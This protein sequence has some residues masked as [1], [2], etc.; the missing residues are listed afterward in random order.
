M[1]HR[2]RTLLHEMH[3]WIAAFSGLMLCT[4]AIAQPDPSLW[5]GEEE[6]ADESDATA[7]DADIHVTEYLTVDLNVQDTDLATVLQAL[8]MQSHKNIVTT[9]NVS[10]SISA[11][12][13]DVTFYE[14]LDAILHANGFAWREE[15]NFI[16]VYTAE[17]Y[18]QI[19]ESER[20][21]V[22]RVFTLDYLNASDAAVFVEPLLSE[23]GVVA[24][25]GDPVPGIKPDE[26]D[27]GSTSWTYSGKLVVSDY[28]ENLEE[29]S[30]L[31]EDLDTRP[32]QVLVEATVLQ[33]TLT[34]DNAWGVDWNIVADMD[35][36]DIT[37]PL[38]AADDL[39]NG[40]EGFQPADNKAFGGGTNVGRTSQP[41]SLKIGVVT[42]DIS[43]F[44]R[45]L[46]EVTDT[47]VVSRPRVLALNRQRGEIQIGRKIGYLST[48]STETSTTQTVQFLDTGTQLLFRP[49]VAKDG[50]IRM[51]LKPK[52]S[53]G[54]IREVTS[55]EG[56][57]VTIPD[58]I[59]QELTTNVLVPDGNTIV[60]GGLF[61]EETTLS[62]RQVPV[63]GDV[64]LLGAAFKGHDDT[65]QRSEIMF[66]ITPRIMKQDYLIAMGNEANEHVDRARIG[67]REGLL[68]W[69]REK[70]VLQ[71]NLEAREYLRKGDSDMALW[72]VR[73]SLSLSPNQPRVLQ[74]QEQLL[75]GKTPWFENSVFE[76]IFDFVPDSNMEGISSIN[77]A[78]HLSSIPV[79][80]E[81]PA[82][83]VI[84]PVS[85]EMTTGSFQPITVDAFEADAALLNASVEAPETFEPAI[86]P[87][88]DFDSF[89]EDIQN[90]EPQFDA[91]PE[92][93]PTT[94]SEPLSSTFDESWE[95][96]A[97]EG[98][99][100]F[101]ASDRR[102][103]KQQKASTRKPVETAADTNGSLN[104]TGAP[105]A[106]T[107]SEEAMLPE[108]NFYNN[109]MVMIPW[110]SPQQM[111]LIETWHDVQRLLGLNQSWMVEPTTVTVEV[112]TTI[113]PVEP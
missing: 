19:L 79:F 77:G 10:A 80:P 41:G 47:T 4:P 6:T 48:T 82:G 29:I 106:S 60:L 83:S 34:E 55:S 95:S 71:H 102:M 63:L 97:F 58:E 73:Q 81:Q 68:P 14:A 40:S 112:D 100:I 32:Q 61:K 44:L 42:D 25:S 31:L 109:Q 18:A 54:I 113:D 62:R 57:A 16:Y 22:H 26:S 3:P 50:F 1:S 45:V 27:V 21:I 2:I 110:M 66:L 67:I 89:F 33:T 93:A 75:S 78:S 51:E 53:E 111:S 39:L 9:R 7:G 70:L 23:K 46:D 28:P 37:N 99:G 91:A 17:E 105:S 43:V 107:T 64:P 69:S 96:T 98:I 85:A 52:V 104:A 13:Y 20:Q 92:T 15:K 38:S 86:E 101:E 65:T 88:Y 76:S 56:A 30:S 8:S 11:V 72:H 12:L 5:T 35:F 84:D 103:A 90:V 74:L 49:F 87:S 59:T 108:C 94:G 36:A 24:L